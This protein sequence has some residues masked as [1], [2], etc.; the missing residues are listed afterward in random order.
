LAVTKE[1]KTDSIKRFRK[2]PKDTSCTEVQVALLTMRINNLNEHLKD[3]KHDYHSRQGL[4]KMVGKRRRLLNYLA[5]QNVERYRKV[6][7]ELNLRK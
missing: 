2:H 5:N 6:L 4:Y 3:N 7:Q 1:M